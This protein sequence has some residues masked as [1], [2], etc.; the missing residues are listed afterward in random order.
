MKLETDDLLAMTAITL[1]VGQLLSHM[2]NVYEKDDVSSYDTSTVIIGVSA[3]SL[4]LL[5][6]IRRGA[7]YS[8]MYASMG[9]VAQLYIL[10]R[11]SSKAKEATIHDIYSMI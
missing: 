5:Y 1:G 11:L 6:Q 2:K 10:Q 4:W 7:N 3:S 9:L 8:A